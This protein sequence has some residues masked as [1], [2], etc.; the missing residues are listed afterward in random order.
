[1]VYCAQG[2]KIYTDSDLWAL[3]PQRF[4]AACLYQCCRYRAGRE[5]GGEG[6][7]EGR[8]YDRALLQAALSS[9]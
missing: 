7:R 2:P 6:G 4:P 9:M 1:M 5:G 3:V 8:C